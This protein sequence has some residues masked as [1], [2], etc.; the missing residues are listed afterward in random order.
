MQTLLQLLPPAVMSPTVSS[1]PWTAPGGT[2]V[3]YPRFAYRGA[4]LDVARHFFTVA[5]V[6]RYIDEIAL[7]K[8][9]YLHLH[10]SDD[11]GWRIAINS[12]PNLAVYGGS[13]EVGGGAGGYYTQA[14]Y[15]AI[16]AYAASRYITVVPEIDMPGPHQRGARLVRAAQLQRR[17]AEALHRHQR[18]VQLAVRAAGSDLHIHRPGDR[19]D[20][21]R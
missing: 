5:Q 6:E 11:Q 2:I 18:R 14:D 8:I 17:G 20:S 21:P 15:S 3:D 7:Y 12:W 16:V 10:L 13:T 19:R 1:G 9:N 4:M